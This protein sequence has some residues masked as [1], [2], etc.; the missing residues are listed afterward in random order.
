MPDGVNLS[1][2]FEHSNV[3]TGEVCNS[4]W[5]LK[6]FFIFEFFAKMIDFIVLFESLQAGEMVVITIF[7]LL[8]NA[9]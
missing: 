7:F 2:K 1:M 9:T 5:L 3:G 8:N 4:C 6:L